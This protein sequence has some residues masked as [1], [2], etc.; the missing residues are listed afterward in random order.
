M[1]YPPSHYAKKNVE[2]KEK[3][4]KINSKADVH[5]PFH[6]DPPWPQEGKR[7][8]PTAHRRGS[9]A[10]NAPCSQQEQC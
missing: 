3:V 10:G 1:S 2:R 6:W 8:P 7:Q 5:L 9:V 4:P